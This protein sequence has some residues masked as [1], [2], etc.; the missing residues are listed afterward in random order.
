MRRVPR[1]KLS[2]S[3]SAVSSRDA[4]SRQGCCMPETC[5]KGDEVKEKYVGTKADKLQETSVRGSP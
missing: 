3:G 2:G 5:D 4:P 1:L